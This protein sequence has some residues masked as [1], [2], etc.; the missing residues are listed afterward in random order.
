MAIVLVFLIIFCVDLGIRFRH[1]AESAKQLIKRFNP[2]TAEYEKYKKWGEISNKY[3]SHIN[4]A[5]EY[6]GKNEYDNA[7]NEYREVLKMNYNQWMTHEYLLEV[8]EKAGYYDLALKEIEWLLSRKK[9]DKRVVSEL[10]TRRLK[11]LEMIKN[12]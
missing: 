5:K 10:S 8:Y 2:G 4:I 11:I 3:Y 1:D 9:V 12:K 6:I 7:I